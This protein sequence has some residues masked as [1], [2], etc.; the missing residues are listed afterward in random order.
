MLYFRYN[1]V[2]VKDMVATMRIDY[3]DPKISLDLLMKGLEIN[4]YV[5]SIDIMRNLS[6]TEEI[7]KIGSTDCQWRVRD[8][9]MR[10]PNTTKELLMTCAL[11]E[12]DWVRESVMKHPNATED[13]WLTCINDPEANVRQAIMMN[14]NATQ[15]ILLIGSH[16]Q[17]LGVQNSAIVH[18][19]AT[20]DMLVNGCRDRTL[21]VSVL[22]IV[23]QRYN[24]NSDECKNKNFMPIIFFLKPERLLQ[25]DELGNT[26]LMEAC[27]NKNEDAALYLYNKGA[28]FSD[29]NNAGQSALDILKEFDDLPTKL[30]SL[31][32][33]LILDQ[34][35]SEDDYDRFSL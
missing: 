17:N 3:T 24:F 21:G 27:T 11:D 23:Q 26:L 8:A 35:M 30:Q 14:P 10:N 19:N 12:M 13:I 7:L 22:N 9:A 6:A 16:D 31:K 29:E 4:D 20:I 5:V 2:H 1:Y 28:D 32:E 34:E 18:A 25:K 33:K 15:K